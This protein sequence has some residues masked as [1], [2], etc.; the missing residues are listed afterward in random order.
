MAQLEDL[1]AEVADPELRDALAAEVAELKK[2]TKF[3][4]VFERHIPEIAVLG[5][6][7]S[8]WVTSS[9]ADRPGRALPRPL[10]KPKTRCGYTEIPRTER[11]R[12]LQLRW[13]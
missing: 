2:R 7:P 10:V 3:G 6:A 9:C 12:G 13:S 4:L 11:A 8:K 5:N 1:V